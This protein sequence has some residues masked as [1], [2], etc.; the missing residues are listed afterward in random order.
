ML[1]RSV[2]EGMADGTGWG[3][4]TGHEDPSFPQPLKDGGDGQRSSLASPLTWQPRK[5]FGLAF[6]FG[7]S[8]SR[9]GAHAEPRGRSSPSPTRLQGSRAELSAWPHVPGP[10]SGY[11]SKMLSSAAAARLAG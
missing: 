3:R 1:G 6:G 9:W 4:D 2:R 11:I 8:A 5:A 10:G 7:S